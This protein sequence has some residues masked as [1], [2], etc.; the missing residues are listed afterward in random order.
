M[1]STHWH[2][3]LFSQGWQWDC[4]ASASVVAQADRLVANRVGIA[5][6]LATRDDEKVSKTLLPE[7]VQ[8]VD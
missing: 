5:Q 8:Y 6:R 3:D 2:L 1:T 7:Y 4:G